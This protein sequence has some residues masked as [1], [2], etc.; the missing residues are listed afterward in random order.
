MTEI[1]ILMKIIEQSINKS[2][3][4]LPTVQMEYPFFSLDTYTFLFKEISD[5]LVLMKGMKDSSEYFFC[6][7]EA[8]FEFRRSI[9]EDAANLSKKLSETFLL[10]QSGNQFN[11]VPL[12]VSKQ[13]FSSKFQIHRKNLLG[14]NAFRKIKSKASS[15]REFLSIYFFVSNFIEV[16]FRLI[17]FSPHPL[18]K[19]SIDPIWLGIRE[20]FYDGWKFV[21]PE[22]PTF[23]KYI[24]SKQFL[25]RLEYALLYSLAVLIACCFSFIKSIAK[26]F[27]GGFPTVIATTVVFIFGDTSA[28]SFHLAVVRLGG[29]LL[30]TTY[31][32]VVIQI[33][34][35]HPT[36]YLIVIFS[37]LFVGFM[38]LISLEYAEISAVSSFIA[39]TVFYPNSRTSD[40][41]R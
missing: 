8:L 5:I 24:K 22:H 11:K 26:K 29:T 35:T 40:Y 37:T 7:N 38:S 41:S 25:E 20:T 19:F 28:T 12:Q 6:K 9:G 17:N 39:I 15:M 21:S 2:T 1:N 4:L 14:N 32:F 33:L 10:L 23:L 31:A 30:G 18:M 36:R 13:E 27:Y 34:L 16:Y 3:L